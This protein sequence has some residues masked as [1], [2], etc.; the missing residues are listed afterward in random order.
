[1]KIGRMNERITIQKHEVVVD[2]YQNHSN[3]WN[4]YFSCY[5]YASTY[6]AN[7]DGD[8]VTSEERSITFEVRY[9][10]ELKDITSTEYRVL[11]HDEAYNILSVDMMNYQKKEIRLTCRKEKR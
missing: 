9:C 10:P 8:P 2:K 3:E 1:M 5:T 11:F 6:T 7:E 4:D